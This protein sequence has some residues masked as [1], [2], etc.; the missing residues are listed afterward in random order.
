MVNMYK[1]Y[2]ILVVTGLIFT[3]SLPGIVCE[4]NGQSNLP[5]DI[6]TKIEKVTFF[7]PASPVIY[8]PYS[9]IIELTVE[10]TSET[11]LIWGETMPYPDSL[12]HFSVNSTYQW[13]NGDISSRYD[14]PGNIYNCVT[15]AGVFFDDTANTV[16]FHASYFENA[17]RVHSIYDYNVKYVKP[18]IDITFVN[19]FSEN[20]RTIVVNSPTD[21]EFHFDIFNSIFA[22]EDPMGFDSI[23][24]VRVVHKESGAIYARNYPKPVLNFTDN[25]LLTAFLTSLYEGYNTFEFSAKGKCANPNI[26]EF[27]EVVTVKVFYLDFSGLVDQ[28]CAD[29]TIIH[30]S[31]IPEGGYFEG[32]G[33][34]SSTNQ[35]N[36]SL[37]NPGD[38]TITYYY[39][40]DSAWQSVSKNAFINTLPVID[41]DGQREVCSN[42]YNILYTIE[43]QQSGNFNYKWELSGGEPALYS[44]PE[45]SLS[46]HWLNAGVG[47][48]NINVTDLDK[49]CAN[50]YEFIVDIDQTSAPSPCSMFVYN[51]NLLVC[52]ETSANYYVWYRNGEVINNDTTNVPYYFQEELKPQPDEVF[53]VETSYIVNSHACFTRSEPFIYSGM[54]SLV[55]SGHFTE[56]TRFNIFPNPNRGEFLIEFVKGTPG[57]SQISIFNSDGRLIEQED[58]YTFPGM[59]HQRNIGNL[60][61]GVYFLQ[62]V[63]KQDVRFEKFVIY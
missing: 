23:V 19:G 33:I 20:G 25:I 14:P 43:N 42:D 38:N 8:D 47:K 27:S 1:K 63:T 34:M 15:T 29:N 16:F 45:P 30:L 58:I 21:V 26:S 28:I 61:A 46:V 11:E 62:V 36:P 37:A 51:D 24:A 54:R 52:S 53:Y 10:T 44:G 41:L 22:P 60:K 17:E 18:E 3:T 48:I 49:A 12:I 57:Y 39:Y 59:R 9:D 55:S 50:S 6:N 31:G 13:D 32:P 35:F 40:V 2:L 7:K 56:E 5:G 4:V